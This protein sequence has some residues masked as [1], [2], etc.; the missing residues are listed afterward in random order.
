MF[1]VLFWISWLLPIF[2]TLGYFALGLFLSRSEALT[3]HFLPHI[4][5]LSQQAAKPEDGAKDEEDEEETLDEETK[6]RDQTV[7]GAIEGLIREYSSELN[8]PSQDSDSHPRK[9]RKEKKEEV[10]FTLCAAVYHLLDLQ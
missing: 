9:K 5:I 3:L 2:V 10:T 4:S 7:K 8:A 6:R 1:L